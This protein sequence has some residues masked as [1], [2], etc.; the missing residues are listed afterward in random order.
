MEA[1]QSKKEVNDLLQFQLKQHK[2]ILDQLQ[3]NEDNN[4]KIKGEL[5]NFYSKMQKEIESLFY[6]LN[7][8]TSMISKFNF[9]P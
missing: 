9:Q 5:K 6:N 8:R 7:S 1:E 4:F 3:R 2:E